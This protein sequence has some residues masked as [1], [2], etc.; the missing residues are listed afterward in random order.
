MRLAGRP[1]PAPRPRRRPP[2]RPAA[3]AAAVFADLA[4]AAGV[5]S[6]VT[7]ADAGDAAGRGLVAASALAAGDV[8]LVVPSSACLTLDYG[9]GAGLVL[10]EGAWPRTRA[11]V[12]KD[13][14]APWA[15][16]LA[17][18]LLDAVDGAGGAW[19]QAY[20]EELLPGPAALALPCCLPDALLDA[21]G[22]AG[23]AD[24]ARDQRARL[25]AAFPGLAAPASDAGPVPSHFQ[26]AFGCV[27]SRAFALGGD[28]FAYVPFVDAANHERDPSADFMRD[29][30]DSSVR[31]VARRA[32]AAGAPVTVSYTGAG[33][34]TNARL[35]AQYGFVPAGGSPD[36]RVEL[37]V[38]RAAADAGCGKGG[39]VG[40]PGVA[41]RRSGQSRPPTPHPA[42]PA[43][44]PA[45]HNHRS[46]RPAG[47][48]GPRHLGRRPARA[49]TGGRRGHPV[50]AAG[51]S[52]GRRGRVPRAGGR[53][54][55]SGR[56]RAGGCEGFGGRHKG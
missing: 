28:S 15:F 26:W 45:R 17:L 32:V 54:A 12:A 38:A 3:S 49:R 7:L 13:D 30:S 46:R 2:P 37:D 19:W 27:R 56:R 36:D 4:S 9:S 24:R 34:A 20:A 22:D 50:A 48:L 39:A 29:A 21:L 5:Q 33:G 35:F 51:G 8:A 55:G 25:D 47:R 1:R 14:A 23:L 42:P 31:L 41:R 18:A 52:G 16:I 11:G 10:P 53:V 6:R 43:Q 40:W 44:R